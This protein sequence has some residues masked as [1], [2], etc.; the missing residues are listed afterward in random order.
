MRGNSEFCVMAGSLWWD[1]CSLCKEQR[2][3]RY[4]ALNVIC[5]VLNIFVV[6]LHN[7]EEIS[8]SEYMY[9]SLYSL[10]VGIYAYAMC[11]CVF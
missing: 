10:V 1:D 2:F 6:V 7:S 4:D 9:K 3:G 11:M 8:F 5:D